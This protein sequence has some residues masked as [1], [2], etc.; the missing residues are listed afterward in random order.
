M[1]QDPHVQAAVMFGRGRLQ[2]GI[3]VEP[4]KQ[5]SVDVQD[6]AAVEAFKDLIW[7]VIWI[8]T[9]LGKPNP[10]IGPQWNASI[11]SHHNIHVF[12]ER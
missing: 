9:R 4:K 3:L 12:S 5:L 11:P 1:S 6:A 7:W 10:K 2:N 8:A